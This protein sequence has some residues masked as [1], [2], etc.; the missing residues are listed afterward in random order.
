MCAYS[1][2]KYLQI[3]SLSPRHKL[4]DGHD[5]AGTLLSGLTFRYS[6]DFKPPI[7]DGD[8]TL[9]SVSGNPF[10]MY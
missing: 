5:N 8:D 10:Y 1:D 3:V 6:S 9:T 2:I 4:D 7:S